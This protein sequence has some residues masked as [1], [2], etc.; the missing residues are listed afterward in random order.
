MTARIS[1]VIA[2][3]LIAVPPPRNPRRSRCTPRRSQDPGVYSGRL[4]VDYPTP[5]EPAT[6]EAIRKT[7]EQIHAYVDQAAPVRVIDGD[8][9]APVSGSHAA[10]REGGAGAHRHADP[11]LRVGRDLRRHVARCA[12]HRRSA[13]PPLHRRA[14]LRDGDA[15]RACEKATCRLEPR[16]LTTRR[17]QH[18]LG[19]GPSCCQRALD[20]AGA[21]CAALHQ[22]RARGPRRQEAAAVDRQLRAVRVVGAVPPRRTARWRAIARCRIRCGSTI[23]T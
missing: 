7:L 21:M 3:L 6:E 5:Y 17:P 8:T 13:L 15:G 23:S 16:T 9:G 18:G 12:G 2:A 20:D 11:H 19:C 14:C 22:G 4:K 10:A 1:L